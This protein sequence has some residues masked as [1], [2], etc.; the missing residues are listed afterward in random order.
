MIS[1]SIQQ[2]KKTVMLIFW[3]KTAIINIVNHGDML[4]D[5]FSSL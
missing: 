4:Y 2:N 5:K 1:I 3:L